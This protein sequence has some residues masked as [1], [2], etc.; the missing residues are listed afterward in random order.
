M[1]QNAL[2]EWESHGYCTEGSR[3]TETKELM[4][5]VPKDESNDTNKATICSITASVDFCEDK[6]I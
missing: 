1:R 6:G 2:G 4:E 5:V 3:N